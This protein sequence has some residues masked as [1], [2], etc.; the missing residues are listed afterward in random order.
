MRFAVSIPPNMV[1]AAAGSQIHVYVPGTTNHITQTLYSDPTS[2]STMAN[3]YT[4]PGGKVSFYLPQPMSVQIGVQPAGA[5]SPVV[6]PAVAP[7]PKSFAYSVMKIGGR[8][9]DWVLS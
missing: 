1:P 8:P 2:A 9:S 4:H 7:G 5:A 6:S 3:P